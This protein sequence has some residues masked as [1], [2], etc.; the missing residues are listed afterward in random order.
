MP[1]FE[2]ICY[3]LELGDEEEQH[4]GEWG[5]CELPKF[6]KAPRRM[7]QNLTEEDDSL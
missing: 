2:Q 4:R 7:Q 3:A 1:G 6:L 5:L